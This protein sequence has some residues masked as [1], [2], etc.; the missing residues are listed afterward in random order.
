MKLLV[1]A[2]LFLICFKAFSQQPVFVNDGDGALYSV[3]LSNCTSRFIDTLKFDNKKIIFEDIAFTPDGRLWGIDGYYLYRIDTIDASMTRI[4]YSDGTYSAGLVALDDSSLIGDYSDTLY[5]IN[6]RTA[7]STNLGYIS[8]YACGDFSWYG[9][10]LYVSECERITKITFKNNF[11]EVDS[12]IALNNSSRSYPGFLGLVTIPFNRS[13]SLVGFGPSDSAYLISPINGTYK[14]ICS[15]I[16][17]GVWGAASM[18]FPSVFPIHLLNFSYT[19]LDKTVNLQW[20]TTTETNSNYFL[21]QRSADGTNFSTIG[22]MPAANNSSTLKQY[23]FTDNDPLSTNYY[24]LKEV[25]LNGNATYSNTLLVKLPQATA[26]QILQNPVQNSLQVQVNSGQ[27]KTSTLC[28]FDFSGRRLKTLTVT[29]GL[30][31]IDI[32]TLPAGVYIMQL[33]TNNGDLYN[34]QFVKGN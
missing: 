32:S 11:T 24:R 33:I 14:T 25:D 17:I 9:N 27:P 19:L 12:V 26:L 23:T 4:G 2:L 18:S 1:T 30:Q 20:Q 10:D 15:S 22:K 34:E 21:I 5:E 6:V 7:Q 29:N 16:P 31:T 28:I 8:T 13:D 3:N